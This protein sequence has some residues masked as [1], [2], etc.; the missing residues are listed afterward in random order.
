MYCASSNLSEDKIIF[1][2]MTGLSLSIRRKFTEGI[3]GQKKNVRYKGN[4]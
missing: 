3:T 4:I 1:K 2:I